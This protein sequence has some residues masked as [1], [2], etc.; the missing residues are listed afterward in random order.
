M[1]NQSYVQ[2]R[3]HPCIHIQET[4]FQWGVRLCIVPGLLM[5]LVQELNVGTVP[6]HHNKPGQSGYRMKPG[7]Y[8]IKCRQEPCVDSTVLKP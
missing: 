8:K 6:S 2:L 5:H 1:T 3:V 4:V 7:S